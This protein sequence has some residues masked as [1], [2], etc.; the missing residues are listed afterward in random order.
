MPRHKPPPTLRQ[1]SL[2]QLSDHLARLWKSKG[3]AIVTSDQIREYYRLP[4][5]ATQELVGLM[6]ERNRLQSS[7]L[8]ILLHPGINGLDLSWFNFDLEFFLQSS[9]RALQNLLRLDLSFSLEITQ[10]AF[11]ELARCIPNIRILHLQSTGCTDS[12][13]VLLGAFCPSLQ[14]LDLAWCPVT[15]L[16]LKGLC[17]DVIHNVPT[18]RCCNLRRLCITGTM[19]TLAGAAFILE[20][21]S[22]LNDLDFVDTFEVL[23]ALH[24]ADL[25]TRRIEKVAKYDLNVLRSTGTMKGWVQR[26]LTPE[27]FKI[28]TTMCPHLTKVVVANADTPVEG[29]LLL[30]RCQQLT[31]LELGFGSNNMLAFVDVLPLL[32]VIG[33]QLLSLGLSEL[34][35]LD[36]YAI[37]TNCRRLQTLSLCNIDGYTM[38][39]LSHLN[40]PNL[41][42]FTLLDAVDNPIS[43]HVLTSILTKC[44]LL[45]NLR[46]F[47]C[48]CITAPFLGKVFHTNR[49]S[50]LE[51]FDLQS[52]DQLTL[53]GIKLLLEM[54]N[55]LHFIGLRRCRAITRSDYCLL[56]HHI[57]MR[58][59]NVSLEWMEW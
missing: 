40:F 39:D 52:C 41:H 24:S 13:L 28:A 32:Q 56:L 4:A 31:E 53:R 37:S 1:I 35:A 58:N 36:V 20:K 2:T 9:A 22:H 8:I 33:H 17:V 47:F 18:P 19:V 46:I 55:P 11:F 6:K 27:C 43:D 54:E 23:E 34:I 16:G 30:S 38:F 29:L 25:E 49:L 3:N 14:D 5:D 51:T 45:M 15:D 50:H 59:L 10:T 26:M 21:L 48:A 42:S 7:H 57:R 12:V 44:P